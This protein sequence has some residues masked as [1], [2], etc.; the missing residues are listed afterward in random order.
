MA[1]SIESPPERGKA[2][3]ELVKKLAAQFEASEYRVKIIS[4]LTST[5]KIVEM[6]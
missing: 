6:T 2:N 3:T 4:G 1:I 5:K